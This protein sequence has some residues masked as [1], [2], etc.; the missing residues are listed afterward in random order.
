MYKRVFAFGCSMTKYAWPTWADIYGSDFPEYYNYGR[1]GGGNQFISNQIVE[2]SIKHNIGKGDLLLIMWTGYTR[3]DTYQQW[4]WNTPGNI[5]T[6][7]TYDNN[8]QELYTPRGFMIRDCATIKMAEAY[9]NSLDCDS[10]IFTMCN[11]YDPDH[12][13]DTEEKDYDVANFYN[14]HYT[15]FHEFL[16]FKWPEIDCSQRGDI[17]DYHPDPKMHY[18]FLRSVGLEPTES[19]KTFMLN[20]QMKVDKYKTH[21]EVGWTNLNPEVDRL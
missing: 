21:D 5:Y 19:M 11:L 18:E 13:Y 7:D 14:I 8:I 6:Q 4:G 17:Y 2:A 3:L 10:K 12:R 20:W 9:L 15:S 1:S 16:N